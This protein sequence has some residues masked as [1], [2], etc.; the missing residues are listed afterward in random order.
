MMT[1]YYLRR[2]ITLLGCIFALS[3][4]IMGCTKA[5]QTG[6]PGGPAPAVVD[7][8]HSLQGAELDT[9]QQQVQ[10]IMAAHT[11]VI[12]KMKFVPEQNFV[13]FSY[14]AEAGGEGPEIF[15]ASREIIH[16]LYERGTLAET[17][18]IDQVAFPAAL[19]AFQYGGVGYASPWLTDV[20]LLYFRTD[21]ASIPV[22]MD[23]LFSQ[24]GVSI[25]T[26]DTATLSAWWNGQGG[27][28]VNAGNPVV[29]DPFNIAFLNQ[30]LTW[31][32][33]LSL[34]IDPAVLNTFISGGTPYMIAGASQAKFLTQQ[35]VPWGSMQLVELLGGQGQPLLGTTLGI[36]N[37][38]IKTT[39]AMRP[40]IE[41]VQKA[42][43]TPEVEGAMLQA[44]RLLPANMGFYQTPEALKGVFPQANIAL[45]KAWA[46]EG[47]ALEFKLIPIQDT[48]WSTVLVGN[49]TPE[50][51]LASAQLEAVKALAAK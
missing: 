43:Q 24:G 51:A 22:S 8:W 9:L 31:R 11:E 2:T 36:A 40:S 3:I 32:N 14:Q 4:I 20:P 49:V 29:D 1:R 7:I 10:L 28:L 16:Q 48:A 13:A 30:L 23:Q 47:N 25:A 39:E 17:V 34:R 6:E 45:T 19:S 38:A 15:I 18:Y 37:S 44:G 35:N 50:N 27:R 12:V 21:T 41:I 26:P 5:P 42:L 33:D 46:L